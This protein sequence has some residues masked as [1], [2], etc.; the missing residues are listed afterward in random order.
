MRVSVCVRGRAFV[1]EHNFLTKL[2][3]YDIP[4]K[5][6][7]EIILCDAMPVAQ[8][9]KILDPPPQKPYFTCILSN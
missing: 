5:H 8:K 1:F 3:N 9:G 2:D 4:L 7:I 6:K